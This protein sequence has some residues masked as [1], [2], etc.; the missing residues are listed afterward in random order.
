MEFPQVF[1]E[2]HLRPT[3]GGGGLWYPF[4]PIFMKLFQLTFL[5]K[6][7][8]PG[9][10]LSAGALNF[11]VGHFFGII[12]CDQGFHSINFPSNGMATSEN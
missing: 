2:E 6:K 9:Y 7:N 1:I 4:E 5:F 3:I 11:V 12:I 8:S 10:Q